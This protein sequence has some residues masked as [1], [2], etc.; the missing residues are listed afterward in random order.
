MSTA[1]EG[2]WGEGEPVLFLGEWC[3]LY[4]RRHRWSE[5]DA[6]V[7]PYHWDDRDK[8]LTDRRF[9]E[10]LYEELLFDA[11]EE[12]NEVHGTNHGL[13]AQDIS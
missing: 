1:L 13:P 12:L 6:E 7:L 5:L 2:S 3:R 10:A 4:S 11:S 9:L 8:F